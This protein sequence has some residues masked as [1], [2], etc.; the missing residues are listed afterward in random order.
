MTHSTTSNHHELIHTVQHIK[1][2]MTI[3]IISSSNNNNTSTNLT[4]LYR[5]HVC[6]RSR[7][8]AADALT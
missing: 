6:C 8:S 3:I 5:G 4:K 7:A 2:Y 1:L